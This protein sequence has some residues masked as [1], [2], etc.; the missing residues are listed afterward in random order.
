MP[1]LDP[2]IFDHVPVWLDATLPCDGP[3]LVD[4]PSPP[5]TYVALAET[6][7]SAHV[8]I[9]EAFAPAETS[10]QVASVVAAP[11]A[12][13]EPAATHPRQPRPQTAWIQ[14]ALFRDDEGICALMTS[15]QKL[16]YRKH[17]C[18]ASPSIYRIQVKPVGHAPLATKRR[19]TSLPSPLET[20]QDE[21]PSHHRTK[22]ARQDDDDEEEVCCF[23]E[24][25]A[26]RY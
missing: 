18:I 4:T 19:I 26:F 11:C 9:A 21:A 16:W 22:R 13:L 8:A 24:I 20:H 10:V 7:P 14:E 12:P 3:A 15:S 6:F 25:F 2:P 5:N 17:A 23:V 1:I